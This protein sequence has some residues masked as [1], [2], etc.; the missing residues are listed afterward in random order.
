[1]NITQHPAAT[2]PP[3]RYA[4]VWLV[5]NWDL[6]DGCMSLVSL[7]VS[8]VVAAFKGQQVLHIVLLVI[9]VMSIVAFLV[10]LFR[11]FFVAVSKEGRRVAELLVQLPPEVDLEMLV[12]ALTCAGDEL[13]ASLAASR[14]QVGRASMMGAPQGFGGMTMFRQWGGAPGQTPTMPMMG[15]GSG[16]RPWQQAWGAPPGANGEFVQAA[17][18]YGPGQGAFEQGSGEGGMRRRLGAGRRVAPETD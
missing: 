6:H 2:L 13:G 18:A 5:G 11:P 9:A 7:Y 1:M 17:G 8:D 4:Y 15:D 3:H 16:A 10:L 12:A 14:Q